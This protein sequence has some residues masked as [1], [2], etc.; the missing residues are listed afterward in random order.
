MP[1]SD[2][3]AQLTPEQVR[4]ARAAYEIRE[5]VLAQLDDEDPGVIDADDI[6]EIV[7]QEV[8]EHAAAVFQAIA[9]Q[10]GAE[11]FARLFAGAGAGTLNAIEADRRE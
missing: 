3:N 2:E 4:F 9:A 5:A 11:D 1:W 8:P 7:V 6:F 10:Q